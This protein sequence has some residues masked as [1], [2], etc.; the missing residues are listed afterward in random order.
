HLDPE[1]YHINTLETLR[2]RQTAGNYDFG[3]ISASGPVGISVNVHDRAN[4]TPNIYAVYELSLVLEQDTLFYSRVDSFGYGQASQMFIDR[5]YPLLRENRGG[6]QRLYLVN[7]NEL[8]FYRTDNNRGIADLPEGTYDLDVIAKDFYGNKSTGSLNLVVT[9]REI[10]PAGEITAIPAY[11][12]HQIKSGMEN[13]VSFGE[14]QALP[15]NVPL[16]SNPETAAGPYHEQPNF[17][18]PLVYSRES[19]V[20]RTGMKLVPGKRQ[21]LYL[22]DQTIWIDF[23]KDALFDT[24][25]VDMLV[26]EWDNL[27]VIRFSPSHIPLKKSAYLNIILQNPP[28]DPEVTGIYEFDSRQNKYGYKGSGFSASVL[29]AKIG[30]L[31]EFHVRQDQSSPYVGPPRIEK[32]LSGATVVNI[33]I[34]DEVS[35]IDYHRSL[36]EVNG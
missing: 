33:P 25:H 36:V 18:T 12:R 28:V 27:P 14:L 3:S 6:F 13:S 10:S 30:Q 15:V 26:S 35:G 8:P 23:P 34:T 11:P 16:L 31:G 19:T 5:V 20:K 1:T 22:P 4:R 2:P 21:I 17:E 24:L 7:G 29:R 9:G 32:D